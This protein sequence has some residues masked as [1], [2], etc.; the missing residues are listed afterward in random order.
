MEGK[1]HDEQANFN[2]RNFAKACGYL[3]EIPWRD[4]EYLPV[5]GSHTAAAINIAEGGVPGLHAE[6]C[7]EKGHVDTNIVL[8]RCP[9]LEKPMVE[10]IRSIVFRRELEVACPE[11]PDFL[12][13][14]VIRGLMGIVPELAQTGK[15][16]RMHMASTQQ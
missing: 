9:S 12:N 8:Q 16:R 7:N 10:G 14:A 15:K 1:L 11:L 13:E 4:I 3:K 2:K 5:S 6:L